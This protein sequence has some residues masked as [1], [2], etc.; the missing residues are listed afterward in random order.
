MKI[1]PPLSDS[2]TA[3]ELIKRKLRAKH[4]TQKE[5]AKR[6]G[7]TPINLS[8]IINGRTRLTKE[9]ADKIAE[10]L[11]IDSK[12]LQN[13]FPYSFTDLFDV[14]DRYLDEIKSQELKL[15]IRNKQYA[16]MDQLVQTFLNSRNEGIR[17]NYDPSTGITTM[18]IPTD[19]NAFKKLSTEEKFEL[20]DDILWYMEKRIEKVCKK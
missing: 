8:N 3:G 4:M 7:M 12:L 20:Y 13:T 14:Y 6:I 18:I 11:E 1:I 19:Q 15:E 17:N 2:I 5:L 10:I 16:L 9:N